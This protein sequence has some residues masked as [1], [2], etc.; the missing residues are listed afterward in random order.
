MGCKPSLCGM[1]LI[2]MIPVS[3]S[4]PTGRPL[5]DHTHAHTHAHTCTHT[6]THKHTQT[7]ARSN[8]LK[9]C[10]FPKPCVPVSPAIGLK[11]SFQTFPVVVLQLG[12]IHTRHTHRISKTCGHKRVRACVR[13]CRCVTGV[14][15][16][17]S[18]I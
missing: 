12:P 7:P 10:G 2:G 6:N 8:Q 4:G 3:L 14:T 15:L 17:F 16:T 9:S 1:L 11:R 5:T 13:A 18:L